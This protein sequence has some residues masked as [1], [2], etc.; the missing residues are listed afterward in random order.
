M[1]HQHPSSLRTSEWVLFF[2]FL[3]ILLSLFI[4]SKMTSARSLDRLRDM[5]AAPLPIEMISVEIVG[6]VQKPGTYSLPKG[7]TAQLALRKARLKPFADLSAINLNQILEYSCQL[8][9]PALKEIHVEVR[10]CVKENMTLTLPAGSRICD[11]KGKVELTSEA[12][13][14]FF[15]RRRLLKEGEII[16]VTPCR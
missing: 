14:A 10:G 7:T 6:C 8:D 4:I 1:N 13:K 15:K 5:P 12:N 9:V 11:L 3:S 2:S 16:E